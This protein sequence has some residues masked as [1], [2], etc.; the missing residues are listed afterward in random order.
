MP[1]Y[2][3]F[4]YLRRYALHSVMDEKVY[5]KLS[6]GKTIT[7][8]VPSWGTAAY[9]LTSPGIDWLLSHLTYYMF[10]LDVQLSKF[11][12]YRP[13]F[14]ALCFCNKWMEFRNQCPENTYSFAENMRGDCTYSASQAGGHKRMYDFPNIWRHHE[15]HFDQRIFNEN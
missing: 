2:Y 10:P 15:E 12:Q 14:V 3:H 6:N 11:Q 13:D 5:G 7:H 4:L 9:V 1:P 8:A